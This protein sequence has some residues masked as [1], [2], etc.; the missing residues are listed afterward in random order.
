A[1]REPTLG[2]EAAHERK[3][4]HDLVAAAELRIFVRDRVEAVRA[5][6]E[7]LLHAVAAEGL[8]VLLRLQLPEVLV[9]DPPRRIAVAGLLRTEGRER[10]A[11]RLKDPHE[12]GRDALIAAIDRRG[13]AYEIE[14]FGVGP[15]G[16]GRHAEPLRPVA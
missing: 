5:A 14:V 8:D 3:R 7:D 1:K 16:E 11:G 10:D 12:R 2:E 6:R 4:V 9:A 15:F 13:A